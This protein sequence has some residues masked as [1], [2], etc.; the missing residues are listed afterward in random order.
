MQTGTIGTGRQ[1]GIIGTGLMG[2]PIAQRYLSSEIRVNAFNRTGKKA[3]TL[4]NEGAYVT[5]SPAVVLQ[6]SIVTLVMLSDAAAIRQVLLED[7]ENRQALKGNTIIQM[8]TIAPHE[9]IQM[10]GEII[11]A[12]GHYLEAPVL[13]SIPQVQQ[14]ELIIMVGSTEAQFQQWSTVL[15]HL[16]QH[17][18]HIGPVGKAAVLKLALN[19]LIISLTIAFG[20]SLALVRQHDLEIET[21]MEIVRGSALYAPTFDKKL[22]RMLD[23]NYDNPNFPVKHLLKDARLFAAEA[24]RLGVSRDS[25]QAACTVLEATIAAGRGEQDYSALYTALHPLA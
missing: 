9:S 20:S 19:Q 6:R 13:G 2:Y 8:G 7:E 5:D 16:G 12:G 22:Q 14:G 25:I 1:I 23:S 24:E 4:S 11:A 18:H 3:A 17:I 21:F 10:G 15:S